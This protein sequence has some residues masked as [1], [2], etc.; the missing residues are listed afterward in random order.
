MEEEAPRGSPPAH[1]GPPGLPPVLLLHLL[2]FLLDLL[3]FL[4]HLVDL[5]H[6][7]D[8]LLDFPLHLPDFLL[9]LLELL[10]LEIPA[11]NNL[12]S[13]G[14]VKPM[15]FEHF[16]WTGALKPMLFEHSW[17]Q[18]GRQLLMLFKF[19]VRLY[20]RWREAGR[21]AGTNAVQVSG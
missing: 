20:L 14:I 3:D 5:L 16:W 12:N 8:L 21:E 1:S 18:G 10:L 7:L 11:D 9:H 19:L 2:D 17:R 13:L 6:L 15:L 4:L